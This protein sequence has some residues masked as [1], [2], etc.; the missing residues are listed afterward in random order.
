MTWTVK[1]SNP[2]PSPG[3]IVPAVQHLLIWVNN[4]GGLVQLQ[5]RL[6]E[7]E[8]YFR[9]GLEKTVAWFQAQEGK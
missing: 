2:G 4:L 5:G 7:A 8:P 3:A 9:E 1:E 6:K